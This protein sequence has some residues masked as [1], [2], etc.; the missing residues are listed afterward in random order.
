M[1][2]WWLGVGTLWQTSL[3]RERLNWID[4]LKVLV[5]VG[6]FLFHAAQP[7]VATTWLINDTEKS[8]PLSVASGFGF[9]SACR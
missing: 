3:V 8:L 9:L 4:W 2:R 6:A 5:V 1:A 7:F